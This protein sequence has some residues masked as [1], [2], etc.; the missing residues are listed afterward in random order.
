MASLCSPT[1]SERTGAE[2][3]LSSFRFRL[4]RR[5]RTESTH[6]VLEKRNDTV[7]HRLCQR[8]MLLPA[9]SRLLPDLDEQVG[10]ASRL[11]RRYGG[12][13]EERGLGE[14]RL[15]DLARRQ[16]EERL[17]VLMVRSGQ[18]FKERCEALGNA[19]EFIEAVDE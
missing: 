11:A 18:L 8:L 4:V 17:A 12:G 19:S 7:L 6:Q 9:Q 10:P 5:A 15:N 13:K 3:Q 14:R 1:P 16:G 2:R